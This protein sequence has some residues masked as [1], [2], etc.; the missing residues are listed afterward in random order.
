MRKSL[1]QGSV[2]GLLFG[3]ADI[4]PMFFMDGIDDKI[5]AITG[6]F[7]NR[8]AIGL[9]IFTAD[10]PVKA[11]IKGGMI[12]LLLSLPDAVITK[13]YIPIIGTGVIGGLIIGFIQQKITRN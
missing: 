10:F 2:A 11:W 3:I 8:F 5:A 1:I 12:G 7:I 6:A 13:A 4:V 9:F